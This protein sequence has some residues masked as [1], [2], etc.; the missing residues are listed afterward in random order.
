MLTDAGTE[1]EARAFELHPSRSTR[2]VSWVRPSV[3]DEGGHHG[4]EIE[5]VAVVGAG[6]TGA[7]SV[8][9]PGLPSSGYGEEDKAEHAEQARDLYRLR[10]LRRCHRRYVPDQRDQQKE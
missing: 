8:S 7:G 3:H 9:V 10:P 1:A 4:P 5:T 6:V 2:P